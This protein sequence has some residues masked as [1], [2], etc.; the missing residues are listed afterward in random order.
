MIDY[1]KAIKKLRNKLIMTKTKFAKLFGVSFTS[2]N[3][4][5]YGLNK[6]TTSVKRKIVELCKEHKSEL[7][8]VDE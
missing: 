5:G 7:K 6:P 1:Q 8:E 4:L 3:R 2:I